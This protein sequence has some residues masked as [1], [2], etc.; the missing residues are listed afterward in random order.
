MQ[1]SHSTVIAARTPWGKHDDFAEGESVQPSRTEATACL[2]C[3]HPAPGHQRGMFFAM[4]N[5]RRSRWTVRSSF[6]VKVDRS[7]ITLSAGSNVQIATRPIRD[8]LPTAIAPPREAP[9]PGKQRS[10][11]RS[12]FKVDGFPVIYHLG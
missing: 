1:S 8:E 7:V 6:S 4:K 2:S 5:P 11:L 12:K 10:R 3:P 9:N